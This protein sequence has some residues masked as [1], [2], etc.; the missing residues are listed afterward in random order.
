MTSNRQYVEVELRSVPSP[1]FQPTGFPDLGPAEFVAWD[2]GKGDGGEWVPSL[3]VDSAQS[4]A[5]RLE[6]VGWGPDDRPVSE[7]AALPYV[8]VVAAADGTHLT[9]SRVEAHRLASAFV[10]DARLDGGTM[11][12]DV[13]PAR[14]GLSPDRAIDYRQVASQVFRLDPLCLLHGVFFSQLAPKQPRVTRAVSSVIEALE[15]RE[16]HS[17]GVKRDDVDP[18]SKNKE[19]S[20]GAEAGYG[21][22]PYHRVEYTARRIVLRWALDRRQLGSYGLSGE[23]TD[24]L[25][26]VHAQFADNLDTVEGRWHHRAVDEP[27]GAV[28]LPHEGDVRIARSVMLSSERLGLVAKV[29]LL[30]G[31]DGDQSSPSTPNEGRR[32]TCRSERGNPSGSSFA[33]RACCCESTAG[34]AS[35][36]SSGSPTPGCASR[37]RSM[38]RLSSARWPWWPTFGEWPA[39]PH[40]RRRSSTARSVPVARWSASASPMR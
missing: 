27:A 10:L 14:L 12:T 33:C 29:D 13:L 28:P 5:N 9:S 3:L 4:M 7:L 16:A 26:W 32:P 11:K 20:Q 37:S 6:A 23:A 18:S 22:V 36:A 39:T 21:N 31:V 35:T 30:E 24:L 15:V 2:P 25:E 19:Q 8:E 38:R 34:S 40:H 17:G 1:R